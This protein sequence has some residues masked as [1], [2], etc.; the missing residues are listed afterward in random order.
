[1]IEEIKLRD[2]PWD[3]IPWALNENGSRYIPGYVTPDA[4]VLLLSENDRVVAY[5]SYDVS[6]EV[7]KVEI[8]YVHTHL[9]YQ[10]KGH[11]TK[12]MNR[13]FEKYG[14][15]YEMH[16]YQ[17]SGVTENTLKRWGFQNTGEL[18]WIREVERP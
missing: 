11:A 5:L 6:S 16:A 9:P 2:F 13:I 14:S 17:T 18:T 1:M 4:S 15:Q 8:H 12:L 10:K 7:S 3:K